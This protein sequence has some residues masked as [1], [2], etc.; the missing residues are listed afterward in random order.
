MNILAVDE[1]K[2]SLKKIKKIIETVSPDATLFSSDSSLAALATA[3]ETE[4]D[5]VVLETEMSE[6]GGI[7]L[8]GYLKE[9]NPYINLIYLTKHTE[10]AYEAMKLHASGYIKKPGT[11]DQVKSELESLRYPEIRKKYKRV[12]AQTF[13]N[14]ELFVDGE[15]VEFKYKRTKEIVALLIN[16]KGAQTTNGEIIASLWEDDGDPEKKLSYLCNLRQDLQNTFKKLKL[17]GIILKQ[18]GSLAI[19]KDRIECDLYDWLEKKKD[20]K[21][22]YMGDYMNQYSWCEFFHAELDEISYDMEED[23]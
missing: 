11:K 22:K 15:P 5:V 21:Y 12:F 14:F 23:E 9:L 18:R 10:Q 13:G 7:D 20:S 8:G 3:R 6:L 17:D 1:D 2:E 4:M 19:A 16:N